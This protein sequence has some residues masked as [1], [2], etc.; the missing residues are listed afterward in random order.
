MYCNVVVIYRLPPQARGASG[1]FGLQ[2]KFRIMDDDNSHS[3]SLAEF[4]KA[5]KEHVLDW[6]SAQIQ[7]LF[8]H[9]DADKSGAISFDEFIFGVRGVLNDRRKQ[10]VLMAFEVCPQSVRGQSYV[11]AMCTHHCP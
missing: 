7:V 3:I 5:I 8:D 4:T 6:T 9:F 2:R 11:Y 10:L 1:I